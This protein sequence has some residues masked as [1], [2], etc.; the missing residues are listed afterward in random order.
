[1]TEIERIQEILMRY[2]PYKS[3][4]TQVAKAIEQ[5]V[6]KRL[7]K[8]SD[9]HDGIQERTIKKAEQYVIKA[10]I[11]ELEKVPRHE[12]GYFLSTRIDERIAQLKKGLTDD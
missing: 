3:H 4:E 7:E 10:R 6:E 8:Q 11:E 2:I 1:M 12:D 5:Y 9:I